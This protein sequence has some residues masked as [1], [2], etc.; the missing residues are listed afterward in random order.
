MNKISLADFKHRSK[1]AR[2]R[3]LSLIFSLLGLVVLTLGAVALVRSIDTGLMT[4]G[5]LGFKQDALSASSA[6]VEAAISWIQTASLKDLEDGLAAK[7]YSAV[8]AP[9]VEGGGPRLGVP[10]STHAVLIDWLGDGNCKSQPGLNG[11][12]VDSCLQ[13]P[14]A[15]A[16]VG[17]NKVQYFIT[18]LCASTGPVGASND[19]LQ[20][21]SGLSS[22]SSMQR[23][24]ISY[25]LYTRTGALAQA[26]Y[27]RIFTRTEGARGTVTYSEVLVHL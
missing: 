13:Q 4:L 3:G 21:L 1:R 2:Q 8:A 22:G 15:M 12:T 24:G 17:G 14:M 26:V 27:Y 10:A 9:A 25:G 5:N 11:R 23:G 18:R 6:G 7:G 19:C 16:P 20:P